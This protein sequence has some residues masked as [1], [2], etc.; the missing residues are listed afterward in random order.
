[1]MW[2]AS[3]GMGWGM[4]F[5]SVF[6]VVVVVAVAALFVRVFE[7]SSDRSSSAKP[8]RDEALDIARRRYA[9]GELSEE[10]YRRLRDTLLKG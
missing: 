10:E 5:G 9:S 6:W 1:M 2:G 3:E 7:R 4:V 8:D